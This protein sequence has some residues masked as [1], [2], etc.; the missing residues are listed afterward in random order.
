VRPSLHELRHSTSLRHH[1]V[2]TEDH[3]THAAFPTQ[4]HCCN[5]QRAS[6]STPSLHYAPNTV[7]FPSPYL[8]ALPKCFCIVKLISSSQWFCR[9]SNLS[10]MCRCV[11]ALAV[12]RRSA[13]TTLS[14]AHNCTTVCS[15]CCNRHLRTVW[16]THCNP[17]IRR[18]LLHN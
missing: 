6:C 12:Y 3:M 8:L 18:R 7:N 14:A 4:Y 15:F 13:G 16:G 17:A 10:G 2:S 5:T 11:G 9:G 1:D